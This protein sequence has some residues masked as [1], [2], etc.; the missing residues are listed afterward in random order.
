MT[1]AEI[2]HSIGRKIQILKD[3]IDDTQQFDYTRH[4]GLYRKVVMWKCKLD[5]YWACRQV[6]TTRTIKKFQLE[7]DKAIYEYIF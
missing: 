1:K 5:T 2:L 7:I 4:W 3:K 6:I